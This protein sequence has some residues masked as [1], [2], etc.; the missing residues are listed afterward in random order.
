MCHV[1]MC[2]V[3]C[4]LSMPR[5]PTLRT[6]VLQELARQLRFESA[7]AARR[8]LTRAEELTLQLLDESGKPD[9]PAAYP[10]EWVVFRITGLRMEPGGG[11]GGVVVREALLGD[12][13]ALIDRLSAAGKISEADLRGAS[14]KRSNNE[15]SAGGRAAGL[16]NDV[17]LSVAE[18]C[19]RWKV[20]RK[21]LER[22]RRLGLI[23]RRITLGRGREKV[24]YS[25]ACA[26]A[27]ERVHTV[28]VE[29]AGGFA[30]LDARARARIIRRAVRYRARL[31]WSLHK[32]AQRLA[33]REGRSV[34][35]IR[36]LLRAHNDR[37]E[38]PIFD[39]PG[40]LDADGRA[41]VERTAKRGGNLS[42]AAARLRKGRTTAYRV[43][44]ARR[45]DR[46]RGLDLRGPV[47]PMF[48]RKDAADVILGPAAA[49]AGL[50]GRGAT[51]VGE[52]LRVAATIEPEAAPF[53]RARAGA[54]WYLIW[55]AHAGMK[56]LA[57]HGARMRKGKGAEPGIDQIET[58]LI[59]A[60]RLK[61]EMVRAQVPLLVRAIENQTG[62]AAATIP[63]PALK[64]LCELGLESLIDATD[65]FDPF[66]GGRLAAPVGIALTRTV[67]LWLRRAGEGLGPAGRATARV[68]LDG[69]KLADW[70]RRV[71]P[72]Q[73]WLELPID[74]PG[75]RERVLALTEPDRRVLEMRF[76][77]DGGPPRT[78]EDA[79]A[80]AGTTPTR[81]AAIQR[82]AVAMLAHGEPARASKV[83]RKG[84]TS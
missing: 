64:E 21:T 2:Y 62:R 13:P 50:G 27:F 19:A 53:E 24:V 59:W 58:W 15:R 4:S 63:A 32:C 7:D 29:E 31:G 25:E 41:W 20:S 49:R 74:G 9:A 18:L 42:G 79:A 77:L 78:L 3:L 80:A 37:A 38:R 75:V 40:V 36:K 39:E 72:W 22:Y 10:E 84:R 8:Q 34:E 17:W 51:S 1:A 68:D 48:E 33:A 43:V 67:S 46:L 66:K 81:I 6:H 35:G 55:R 16:I 82:K 70:T 69:L 28:R 5:L 73:E 26:L 30:R 71:H 76:G 12:L 47:G 61:A 52:L 83:R 45:A 11:D 57:R 23:S 56:G 14:G 44:G 65:R 54:Q 60:S